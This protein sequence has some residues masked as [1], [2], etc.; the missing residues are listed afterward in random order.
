MGATAVPGF[1]E[2]AF[3]CP[4]CQAYAEQVWYPNLQGRKSDNSGPV[5]FTHIAM[6]VCRRC[7]ATSIWTDR[8]LVH[9]ATATAPMPNTDLPEE[10]R[11]DYLEARS[12]ANQSPRGAA[13]L[14][15]LCVQKLCVHLG[16]PGKDLNDA[17]A[18]SSGRG[19]SR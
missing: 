12:I 4:S 7:G 9:P 2:S 10:I 18:R 11:L 15:R 16:E 19:C 14:L 8:T 5:K 6:A 1:L 13:A 17:S 3:D